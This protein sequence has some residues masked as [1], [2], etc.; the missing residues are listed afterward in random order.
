MEVIWLIFRKRIEFRHNLP[1]T[2]SRSLISK[3]F[4]GNDV[5]AASIKVPHNF[6]TKY[7]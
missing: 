2:S 7:G 4:M 1:K 6:R 5:L 3:R